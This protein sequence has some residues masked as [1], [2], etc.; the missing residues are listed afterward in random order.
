MST[1]PTHKSPVSTVALQVMFLTTHPWWY[2]PDLGL[3]SFLTDATWHPFSKG[4][5]VSLAQELAVGIESS[6][7]FTLIA[8]AHNCLVFAFH[9]VCAIR[10]H[11]LKYLQK[12]DYRKTRGKTFQHKH[13]MI[14]SGC[15]LSHTRCRNSPWFSLQGFVLQDVVC[16]PRL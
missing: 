4:R 13:E 15:F 1:A 2:I 7:D 16:D 14:P 11:R 9:N 12:V 3:T 6:P 10:L 5:G 8:L